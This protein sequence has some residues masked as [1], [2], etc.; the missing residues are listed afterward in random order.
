VELAG[1]WRES[2]RK[3]RGKFGCL[4]Q[5]LE[6]LDQIGHRTAPVRKNH[7]NVGAAL[8]GAVEEHIGNGA[9]SIRAPLDRPLSDIGQKIPAAICSVGMG[10]E[11]RLAAVEFIENPVEGLI[12][13]PLVPV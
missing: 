10:E 12:A 8:G 4:S 2:S 13:E 1:R 7:T 9:S 5:C 6:A 3:L 11:N